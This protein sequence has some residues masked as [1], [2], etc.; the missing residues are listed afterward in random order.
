MRCLEAHG[1]IASAFV[2]LRTKW[3]D[4]YVCWTS[5]KPIR[6]VIPVESTPLIHPILPSICIR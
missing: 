5:E 3:A 1:S 4:F 6:N 2:F